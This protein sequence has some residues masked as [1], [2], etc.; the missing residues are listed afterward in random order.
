M[1]HD[2]LRWMDAELTTLEAASLR[3]RLAVRTRLQSPVVIAVSGQ[4]LINFGSNDYLGLSH[5]PRVVDAAAN[6][7]RE[8]GTGPGGSRFLSGNM[9]LHEQLEERLAAFVG[10]KKALVHTTGF[11]TNAGAVST[12]TDDK[13]IIL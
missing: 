11:M 4:E 6:A 8:W 5:D 2:P 7:V 10:K 1:P 12:L 13:D 9:T 3:R